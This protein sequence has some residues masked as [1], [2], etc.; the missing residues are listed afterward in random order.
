MSAPVWPIA[1]KSIAMFM[2]SMCGVLTST[3]YSRIRPAKTSASSGFARVIPMT[4][5]G[6]LSIPFHASSQPTGGDSSAFRRSPDS[7][8][9]K[10]ILIVVAQ[11]EYAAA[12][13][14][15]QRGGNF[16]H[17]LSFGIVY[18]SSRPSAS[19]LKRWRSA[20]SCRYRQ[21]R[22][23][24]VNSLLELASRSLKVS[25]ATGIAIS[26]LFSRSM[27]STA[28]E[29]FPLFNWFNA[30]HNADVDFLPGWRTFG[31]APWLRS[32]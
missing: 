7:S 4:M 26:T 16:G 25:A 1:A 6:T 27:Q 19:S 2:P 30:I 29:I 22:K 21:H 13:N 3:V 17:P 18:D 14:A 12:S 20:L 23:K 24:G 28:R 9:C 15:L 32:R 31:L 5:R 11:P 8:F 10:N